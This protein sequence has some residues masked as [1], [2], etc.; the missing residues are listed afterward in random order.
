[1]KRLT[2]ILGV[3]VSVLLLGPALLWARHG[4]LESYDSFG[5]TRFAPEKWRELEEERVVRGGAAQLSLRQIGAGGEDQKL[6]FAQPAAIET[7]QAR[8]QIQTVEAANFSGSD[9]LTAGLIGSFYRIDTSAGG[10]DDRTG[11]V[12]AELLVVRHGADAILKVG[13]AVIVCHAE[14]C[15]SATPCFVDETSLGTARM[16]EPVVLTLDWDPV[17]SRFTFTRQRFPAISFDPSGSACA[18]GPGMPA[19]NHPETGLQVRAIISS[20]PTADGFIR[21][22]FDNVK[23]F[24]T[25]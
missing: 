8:M 12:H 5:G 17:A 13:A 20:G 3:V 7:L 24:R 11:D 10:E 2:V 18:P 23:I 6:E 16:G 25:R 9:Q 1:M 14:E 15:E 22:S 4:V 21:A 19:A